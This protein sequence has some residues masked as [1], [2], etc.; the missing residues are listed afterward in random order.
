MFDPAVSAFVPTRESDERRAPESSRV[1]GSE[2]LS[3]LGVA[4][5]LGNFM[6]SAGE[7]FAPRALS[8]IGLPSARR[9][10]P[11]GSTKHVSTQRYK[12]VGNRPPDEAE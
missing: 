12:N 3:R 2:F 7:T 11:R 8:E 6:R 1:S 5:Y 4:P 10:T 9:T